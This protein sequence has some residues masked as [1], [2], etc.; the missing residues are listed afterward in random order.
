M[1]SLTIRDPYGNTFEVDAFA[2]PYWQGREGYTIE[3]P[4]E[5]GDEPDTPAGDSSQETSSPKP[6]K[7]ASRPASEDKE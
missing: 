3:D 1:S 2:L 7:A 5:T 4:S 6:K